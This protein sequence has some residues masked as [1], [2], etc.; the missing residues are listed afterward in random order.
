[1]VLVLALLAGTA[2]AF[3][4]TERLKLERSPI[5]AVKVDRRIFSPVCGC[6]RQRT[7]IGFRLRRADRVTVEMLDDED[8]VV[9]TLVRRR[10]SKAAATEFVWDGR[11]DGGRVVPDG[12]YR[13]RVRLERRDRTFVLPNRIHVD[14]VRPTI[15]LTRVAVRG[16]VVRARYRLSESARPFLFVDGARRAV[17]RITRAEGKLVWYGRIDG[18]PVPAGRY[19]V[20]LVARD[21]A[22]N[23]SRPTRAVTVELDRGA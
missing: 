14:T 21:P 11:D 10:P 16:S 4:V 9:R 3:A 23:R 1:M 18:R 20:Q 8:E 22:G 7:R 12:A 5:A 15:A 17:G 13:P 6:D 2:A 19:R